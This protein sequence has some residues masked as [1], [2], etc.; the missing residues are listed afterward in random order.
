M[1]CTPVIAS[2]TLLSVPLGAC[3]IP[4]SLEVSSDAAVNSPP[5]I[6]SVAGDQQALAEPGPVVFDVGRTAGNLSVS[7]IDTDTTDTLYVRIFVDYNTPDRLDARVRCPP[8]STG[9]A[10]RSVTCN[11]STLCTQDDVTD[12]GATQSHNMT[13]VVFDRMPLEDGSDPAFQAMAPPGLS[14]SK[15]FL[16]KCQNGQP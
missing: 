9:S 5:A 15:F 13:V 6:L 8:S 10:M 16:L 12:I 3:V 1:S 7:L 4:P 2:A 11:L 14:T